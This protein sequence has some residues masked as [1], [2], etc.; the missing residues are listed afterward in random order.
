VFV[1]RLVKGRYAIKILHPHAGRLA[2]Y[3]FLPGAYTGPKPP[4]AGRD[5]VIV[6]GNTG[7]IRWSPVAA[8]PEAPR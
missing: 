2:R 5:G 3:R 6:D 4:S 8:S 7:K 1:N